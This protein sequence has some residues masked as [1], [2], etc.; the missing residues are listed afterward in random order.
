MRKSAKDRKAEI[1]EAVLVLVARIG[2]D[3]VTTSAVAHAIGISQAAV[4][5]HFPTK[6]DIWVAVFDRVAREAMDE[7]WPQALMVDGGPL[8]RVR[9]LIATQL[10]FIRTTPAL[11][12]LL[13]SRELHV[14]NDALRAAVHGQMG[15]FHHILTEQMMAAMAAGEVRGDIQPPR[16]A[17]LLVSLLPGLAM[18]WSLTAHGFDIVAE[19]LA[20]LDIVLAGLRPISPDGA[21][22]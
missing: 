15:R 17:A 7:R 3:R 8:A 22:R 18:R 20:L 12:A 2:P 16:I 9:A 19:G 5:R 11:P 1:V 10:D 13:F 21:I 14:E 4:F 6:N